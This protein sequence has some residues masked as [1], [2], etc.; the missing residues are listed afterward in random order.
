MQP[1]SSATPLSLSIFS[2]FFS[3]LKPHISKSTASFQVILRWTLYYSSWFHRNVERTFIS[4]LYS[5]ERLRSSCNSG[6]ISLWFGVLD[7]SGSSCEYS[8]IH[9]VAT[10]TLTHYRSK[11]HHMPQKQRVTAQ[12][13][14][15]SG[16]VPQPVKS[17]INFLQISDFFSCCLKYFT[18]S[19]RNNLISFMVQISTRHLA[20]GLSLWLSW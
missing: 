5:P 12:I 16:H 19:S 18:C 17:F 4:Q 14:R 15:T 11:L 20:N 6:G 2:V 3:T 9:P 13:L 1:G 10:V 7:I 8:N